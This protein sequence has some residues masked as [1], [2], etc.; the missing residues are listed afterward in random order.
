MTMIYRL[1]QSKRE[2]SRQLRR[3]LYIRGV[4]R[5]EQAKDQVDQ[6]HRLELAFSIL[7]PQHPSKETHL[8]P[9]VTLQPTP[10]NLGHSQREKN[11]ETR[12][13]QEESQ[14]I[15]VRNNN[16]NSISTWFMDAKTPIETFMNRLSRKWSQP[17]S[18]ASMVQFLFMV[19][20]EQAR[21]T[22]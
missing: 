15:C 16:R 5:L 4:S 6:I 22:P 18:K 14:S 3:R 11:R 13:P 21:P 1:F 7:M 17:L 9:L 10:D 19:K 20:L 8:T 2:S 12:S